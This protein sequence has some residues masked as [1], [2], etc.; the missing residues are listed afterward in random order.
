MDIKAYLIERQRLLDEA[1]EEYL[2][3]A[4]RYP[5]SI[6]EAMRYTVLNGGKRLRPIIT[7]AAAEACGGKAQSV[8][9]TAC[10]IELIHAYS[11][12]HDDLPPL[13]NDDYRRGKPSCHVAFGEAIAILTGDALLPLA[14]SLI[15][16]NL[17][18]D[19]I[20]EARVIRVIKEVSNAIGSLGMVGG[21]VVDL[22]TTPET[23]TPPLIQYIHTHKTGLLFRVATR[24]GAILVGVNEEELK[25][26]TLYGENL[27]FAF[28]IVDDLLDFKTGKGKGGAS[29]PGLFGIMTSKDKA[30]SLLEQAIS[31]LEGFGEKA[32]PLESIARFIGDYMSSATNEA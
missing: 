24:C 8:L 16:E 30:N 4:D 19:G 14:F 13:D 31:F 15:A 5:V 27:G 20:D 28:Q 12:I 3:P 21:Q 11:L 26:L 18:T 23:V 7:M 25:S 6:H 17:G 29:Y 2:P 32:L 22:E 1:L 9:P 10:A